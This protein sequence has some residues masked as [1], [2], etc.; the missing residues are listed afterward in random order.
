MADY[1]QLSHLCLSYNNKTYRIDDID[2][3]QNP[4]STFKGF[5]GSETTFV[6]YYKSVSVNVLRLGPLSLWTKMSGRLDD[7]HHSL[8]G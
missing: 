2:W 4:R 8:P 7:V 1:P 6:D 5:D 3:A